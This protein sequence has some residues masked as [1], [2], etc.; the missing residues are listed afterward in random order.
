MG[1]VGGWVFEHKTRRPD[2]TAANDPVAR[3]VSTTCRRQGDISQGCR[4]C[5]NGSRHAMT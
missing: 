5:A 3:L 4:Q 2:E 1:E